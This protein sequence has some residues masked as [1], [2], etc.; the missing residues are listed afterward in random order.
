MT[1]DCATVRRELGVYLLG[2]IDPAD[3]ARIGQ[4]LR[5][6]ARCRGDLAGLAGLPSLLQR[7][8]VAE[9][10]LAG[11]G[12]DSGA[13]PPPGELLDD[14]LMRVSRLR[15][16]DR[17]RLGAAAAVLVAVAG[18]AWGWQAWQASGQPAAPAGGGWAATAVGTDPATGAGATV[19]Y[20]GMRGGTQLEVHVTGIPSGTTCQFWVTSTAGRLIPAGAWAVL[21]GQQHT[22]NPASVPVPAASLRSFDITSGSRLLVVIPVHRPP[23]RSGT[24]PGGGRTG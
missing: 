16:R 22:W 8:P 9:A 19:R 12:G 4:H 24:R 1:G 5:S 23:G 17:W 3:R 18:A 21:P 10:L 2:A 6:C 20:S 14:L 15:R 7:V 13:W 11:D